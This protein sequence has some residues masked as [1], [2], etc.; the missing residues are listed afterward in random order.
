MTKVAIVKG[1]N[2]YKTTQKA[3]EL[4]SEQLSNIG[5]KVLIVPNLLTEKKMEAVV[6]NSNVCKAIAD[7]LKNK[8]G[9]DKTFTI[10]AGTTAGNPMN[11]VR[12]NKYTNYPWKIV[13][14]N[15]DETGKY[16][17]IYSPGLDYE[18]ELGIAQTT[19]NTDLLVSAAKLKTHDVLGF[20]LSLKN[21]MGA[22]NKGR[23][24]D[25]KEIIVKGKKT[26]LYMHGFGELNPNDLSLKQNTGISKSAL[27]INLIRLAKLVFKRKHLAVI[28]AIT[29]MEGNGPLSHGI[30]KKTKMIIAGTDTVAVDRV[31]WE[32]AGSKHTIQYILQAGKVGIGESNLKN[33]KI[34]GEPL[35]KVKTEFKM[36]KW[37]KFSK[38]KEEE[39]RLLDDLTL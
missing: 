8:F 23:K 29:S 33:I 21:L 31:A 2:H 17:S 39:L 38:F 14:L 10:G 30:P 13:D 22:L 7:F 32:I 19:M 28:D 37:F 4:I 15:K 16:F 5:D 34:V 25:T 11:A 27:S 9:N 20:T 36:H 18:I 1:K 3:L 35:E 26:K 24:A 6:T 12:N